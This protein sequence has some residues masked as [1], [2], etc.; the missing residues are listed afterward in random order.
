MK[1]LIL[2]FAVFAQVRTGN[3]QGTNQSPEQNWWSV[4][5]YNLQVKPDFNEQF[6]S[7]SNDMRFKAVQ[8]GEIMQ[9]DLEAP[10][11]LTKIS[12]H[13][14]SALIFKPASHGYLVRFPRAITQGQTE[15][16]HLAF[17]GHP[18]VAVHPPWGN[19]WIWSKD[20][21]GRP[22]MSVTC[23]GSG[24]SIWF[25]CKNLLRDEP[26]SGI[27]MAITV[28]D[29]LVGIANGRLREKIQNQDGTTTY[30]WAVVN[31]INNYDIIPYIGK[32]V[33]WHHDYAGLKGHLDC[34]YWVLDYHL[35]R[36][37]KQFQQ[38]DTMLHCFEYWLGPYPFYEDSYKLVEAPHPG[39]EHQSAIAY[40]ND[41]ANGFGGRDLSG[42]GWGLRWDF[43]LVHESGHEWFGNS[44]TAAND[45]ESWIHE[46]F[47]K[48]LETLYTTCILGTEAGNDYSIGIWK[49]IRN[50][51]P[52][53]GTASSDSYN[54]ASAMLHMIRQILGDDQF[55]ELLRGLNSAFY[56]QDVS[57][58]QIIDFVD[59]FTHQDFSKVF[60]QYLRTTQVP[61]LAYSIEHNRLR[62]RWTHCIRG[63]HMAIKVSVDQRTYF[64]LKPTTSWQALPVAYSKTGT[65]TVDRNF[66]VHVRKLP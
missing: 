61:V 5:Y 29:T 43:I 35:D 30:R 56:H 66:Y 38:V 27:S 46:G 65:L 37:K 7:G 23:E 8:S 50:D 58:E 52:V 15:T 13:G 19:G 28:P 49:R 40:G 63:F 24:S 41:F 55:R 4:I 62:Y 32:Y 33:G 60:D 45:G 34:D 42:T 36:A 9:I 31:T 54:K 1:Y 2:S 18:Q 53:I 51:Q 26:D 22:W 20:Q 47:T 16:I 59:Q 11:I 21:K 12:W 3:A 25:P 17:E 57:S 48:Y 10:M 64:F 14:D 44:L 6:I 39:M